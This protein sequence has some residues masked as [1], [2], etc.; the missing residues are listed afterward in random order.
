[1]IIAQFYRG[2]FA[3]GD[4]VCAQRGQKLCVLI[5]AEDIFAGIYHHAGREIG[6]DERGDVAQLPPLIFRKPR[7]RGA[8]SIAKHIFAEVEEH[9]LRGQEVHIVHAAIQER[10]AELYGCAHAEFLA[11]LRLRRKA[12]EK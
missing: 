7:G 2:K 10:R 9:L 5:F 3:E 8:R 1:M 6:R 12:G 11:E 4:A